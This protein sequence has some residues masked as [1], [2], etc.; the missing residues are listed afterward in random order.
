[1][2][3]VLHDIP[4][5]FVAD[6]AHAALCDDVLVVSNI[7]LVAGSRWVSKFGD[8]HSS[9]VVAGHGQSVALGHYRL[10]VYGVGNVSRTSEQLARCQDSGVQVGPNERRSA[11]S[12]KRGTSVCR[13]GK[14]LTS[15]TETL[16][17]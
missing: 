10:Q 17:R 8:R 4:A 16:N 2:I 15:V 1:M 6:T 14:R 11:S 7:V 5:V 3:I 12:R 9:F 13:N